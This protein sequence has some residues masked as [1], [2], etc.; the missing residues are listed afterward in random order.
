[1]AAGAGVADETAGLAL[2]RQ[3][4][5]FSA[6]AA[7]ATP[8]R[9]NV[10]TTAQRDR[11]SRDDRLDMDNR[12]SLEIAKRDGLSVGK[13]KAFGKGKALIVGK[14]AILP[15]KR[16]K[17]TSLSAQTAVKLLV[18]GSRPIFAGNDKFIQV[19]EYHDFVI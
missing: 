9:V 4:F 10:R 19:F 7:V 18:P 6:S 5:S 13:G 11:V 15:G 17:T 2:P 12:D 16:L 1:M 3:G 8:I 14:R